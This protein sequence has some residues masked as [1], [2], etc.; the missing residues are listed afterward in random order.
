M[1]SER[2][3]RSKRAGVESNGSLG[4]HRLCVIQGRAGE[5]SRLPFAYS[6]PMSSAATARRPWPRW[7]RVVGWTVLGILG[8]AL[9]AF[10]LTV[11]FGAVRGTEFSPQLFERRSYSFYELPLTGI[12]VRGI[13]RKDETQAAELF[14]T[15]NKYITLPAAGVREDWHIITGLRGTRQSKGDAGILMQYL[16]AK[17]GDDYHYWVKWS[18]EHP[19]L[20]AVLWPA[21]QKLGE[22]EL[23][24]F[25][26]DLF[27]LAR[28]IEDPI[29]LRQELDRTAAGKLLFLGK[30]MMDRDDQESARQVLDEA[31]QLDPGNQEIK[32][33]L[34]VAKTAEADK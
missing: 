16:D 18:E 17:D 20:A 6:L 15:S 2:G 5:P 9:T 13:R 25:V 19:K 22:R 8:T 14:I 24:I 26:P 32:E 11:T 21:V 7:V 34:S 1:A 10:V 30:R 28:S 33:A 3:P 27:D 4:D 29:K 23:Y 12:Q 31:A